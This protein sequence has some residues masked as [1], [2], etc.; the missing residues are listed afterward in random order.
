MMADQECRMPN[1]LQLAF[2]VA[3]LLACALAAGEG[4]ADEM[5]SLPPSGSARVGTM[6]AKE[7]S[8]VG[9]TLDFAKVLSFSHPARTII[10]GNPGIVDGTLSDEHTI[11]LTGK[12]LGTT[13]MIVLGEA[14]QE[15]ANLT[16]HVGTNTRQWT[17]VH[18]GTTQQ[19]FSCAGPC[20]PL[21]A[22]S[23]SK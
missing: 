2:A 20:K 16:V 23:E 9:V 1:S 22:P 18:H 14:G 7:L 3:A 8:A 13:N 5:A 19:L 12:A 17:T 10:I 6:V 11:V 15:I 21:V 4:R